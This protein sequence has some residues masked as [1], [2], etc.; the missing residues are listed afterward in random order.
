MDEVDDDE[1]HGSAG[2]GEGSASDGK[3]SGSIDSCACAARAVAKKIPAATTTTDPAT[4]GVIFLT[5]STA[6]RGEKAA[7]LRV[8]H[9]KPERMAAR[10]ECGYK[11]VNQKILV[12]STS[13][14]ARLTPFYSACSEG[15]IFQS[16][17]APKS[18]S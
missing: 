14:I 16:K 7:R 18:S 9:T 17:L 15:V 6:A 12:K 8:I 4:W 13:K 2:M 1:G 3:I 5:V 11:H 10:V